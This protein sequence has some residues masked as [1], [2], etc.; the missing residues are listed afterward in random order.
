M[1]RLLVHES[2]ILVHHTSRVR[3]RF[4]II[5]SWNFA[6]SR[7]SLSVQHHGGLLS[8]S[9]YITVVV[10]SGHVSSSHS[11]VSESLKLLFS[12]LLSIFRV[13]SLS[14]NFLEESLF[15]IRSIWLVLFRPTL[16]GFEIFH[17]GWLFGQVI[18]IPV[19]LY[20]YFIG[21]V[22]FT[23]LFFVKHFKLVLRSMFFLDIGEKHFVVDGPVL[24][25]LF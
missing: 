1:L 23:L 17:I 8:S 12:F 14:Y 25:T 24:L 4:S 22:L 5:H 16:N 19:L 21:E 10:L 2:A 3:H 18:H 20:I 7:S 13:V 11:L 15:R 9:L 6:D